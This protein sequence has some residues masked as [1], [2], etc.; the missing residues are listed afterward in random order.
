M[1]KKIIV[2]LAFVSLVVPVG[3]IFA[4]ATTPMECC[5]IRR[6]IEIGDESCIAGVV[7]APGVPATGPSDRCLI[8]SATNVSTCTIGTIGTTSGT[9]K[10]GMFCAIGTMHTV[11]DWAFVFFVVLAILLT[12]LGAFDLLTSAGSTEKVN[13]GRDKILYAAIGLLVALVARAIPSIVKAII[14]F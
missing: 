7:A 12:L 2:I 5:R 9:E 14:G 3:V 13:S 8:M 10:W 1:M 6:T 4:A 11:V